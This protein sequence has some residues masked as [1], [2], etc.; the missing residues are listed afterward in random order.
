MLHPRGRCWVVHH[1]AA[2][3]L[4]CM[5]IGPTAHERAAEPQTC[6]VPANAYPFLPLASANPSPGPYPL[7][8]GC[9]YPRDPRFVLRKKDGC[10]GYDNNAAPQ[11]KVPPLEFTGNQ[12]GTVEALQ[13]VSRRIRPQSGPASELP[14]HVRVLA[15]VYSTRQRSGPCGTLGPKWL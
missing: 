2:I 15:G 10:Q 14:D 5:A 3:S 9:K 1:L 11:A 7:I 4:L 12:C 6:P 8:A 13:P